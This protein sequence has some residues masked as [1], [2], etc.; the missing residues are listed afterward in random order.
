LATAGQAGQAPQQ[1]QLGIA[2]DKKR[3]ARCQLVCCRKMQCEL[4]DTVVRPGSDAACDAAL[5]CGAAG[6]TIRAQ[7]R[8]G[9]WLYF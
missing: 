6:P 4:P 9:S 8:E 1:A 2:A 3:V 7:I 5:T